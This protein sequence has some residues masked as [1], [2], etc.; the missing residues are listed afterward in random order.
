MANLLA[1]NARYWTR[2]WNPRDL[3]V[4]IASAA[5][6]HMRGTGASRAPRMVP[7]TDDSRNI[8]SVAA[9]LGRRQR[10][11][12]AATASSA[13]AVGDAPS[14]AVAAA[15]TLG[16]TRR[17]GSQICLPGRFPQGALQHGLLVCSE[18]GQDLVVTTVAKTK[19]REEVAGHVRGVAPWHGGADWTNC[20]N[21][22]STCSTGAGVPLFAMLQ[23]TQARKVRLPAQ[24]AHESGAVRRRFGRLSWAP[25][26]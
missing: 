11:A 17:V 12:A 16:A 22:P 6:R 19:M 9:L 26:P 5:A 24:W 7:R 14:T 18:V 8:D 13:I 1:F 10:G 3:L 23:E 21:R 15:P 25:C 4:D 2:P 20:R